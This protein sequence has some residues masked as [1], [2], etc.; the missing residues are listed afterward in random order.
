MGEEYKKARWVGTT[1][2]H[3]LAPRIIFFFG[4]F[5]REMIFLRGCTSSLAGPN[6]LP[7]HAPLHINIYFIA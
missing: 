1:V 3:E 4:I 7:Y 5:R 2:C 6:S